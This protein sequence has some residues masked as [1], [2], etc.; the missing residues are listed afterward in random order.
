MNLSPLPEAQQK[1]W[2]KLVGAKL[3]NRFYLAGGTA[4]A[5]QLVHRESIDFDFFTQSK[6]DVDKVSRTLSTLGHLQIDL[7]EEQSI[8]ARLDQV[9][10]SYFH[11]PYPL[12]DETIFLEGIKIAKIADLVAMKIIAIAQRGTKKDFI[13]LHMILSSGWNF[14]AIFD[15]VNRKFLDTNYN[16]M[17]LL[18]S[19]SYFDDAEEDPMPKML[20]ETSWGQVK[21]ELERWVQEYLIRLGL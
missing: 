18:K 5:L 9:K 3:A 10:V 13:D 16:R 20:K 12:L 7:L 21:R 14:E 19:L 4:I 15:A 8:V 1:L 2:E 6:F 11:Y 17:H